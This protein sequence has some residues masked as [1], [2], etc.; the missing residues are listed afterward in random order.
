MKV[1]F[2]DHMFITLL[3]F[4]F[5]SYSYWS[6]ATGIVLLTL[7]KKK[8]KKIICDFPVIF[9]KIMVHSDLGSV[10]KLRP[11]LVDAKK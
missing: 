2:C 5:A 10:Q 1:S 11:Y 8:K 6:Y 7:K 4:S 3:F 9:L